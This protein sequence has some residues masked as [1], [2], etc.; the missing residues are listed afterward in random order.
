MSTLSIGIRPRT[1]LQ[2]RLPVWRAR[3]E[4]ER[5]F[6]I[7]QTCI[8]AA[9][10]ETFPTLADDA[11]TVAQVAATHAALGEVDDALARMDDGVYGSCLG[12]GRAIDK[13][14]LDVLPMTPR[15]SPCQRERR[16][17]RLRWTDPAGTPAR[18][19]AVRGG[20][21]L[22]HTY[23]SVARSPVERPG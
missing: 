5:T 2:E 15:C 10:R 7:A 9:E 13:D 14:R 4:E 6:L 8:M 23:Q 11:V 1:D 20:T 18:S 19:A 21:A 22:M 16:S 12:C 17:G 3:L